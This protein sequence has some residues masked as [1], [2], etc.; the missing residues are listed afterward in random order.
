[1]SFWKLKSIK[2]EF[3]FSI[4]NIFFSECICNFLQLHSQQNPQLRICRVIHRPARSQPSNNGGR[5][6]QILDILQ[7]LKNWRSQWVSK[8]NLDF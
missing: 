1:M 8:G 4:C 2:V 6:P 3:S 7:S 5:F